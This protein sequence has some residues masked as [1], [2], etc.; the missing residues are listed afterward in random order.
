M[1]INNCKSLRTGVVNVCY[2]TSDPPASG[3]VTEGAIF[4]KYTV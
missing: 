4:V 3:T 1:T 2:G